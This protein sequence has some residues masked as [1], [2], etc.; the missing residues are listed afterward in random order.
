LGGESPI[1]WEEGKFMIF[2]R[3]LILF[4]LFAGARPLL[5]QDF[6][7]TTNGNA[8]EEEGGF[9]KEEFEVMRKS[10][11]PQIR[12]LYDK[13]TSGR[14]SS[15]KKGD[16]RFS[17][18]LE[19]H[20]FDLDGISDHDN[21]GNSLEGGVEKAILGKDRTGGEGRQK[22][23]S[24]AR[25][26]CLS[27]VMGGKPKPCNISA[28]VFDVGAAHDGEDHKVYDLNPAVKDALK[29][30]GEA[31]FE[32]FKED[33]LKQG[34]T[35]DQRDYGNDAIR[36]EAA[37]LYKQWQFK[38]E[39]SWKTLRAARLA[40]FR[41]DRPDS[42]DFAEG[43]AFMKRIG[44]GLSKNGSDQSLAEQV[45]IQGSVMDK[46]FCEVAPANS[47]KWQLCPPPGRTPATTVGPELRRS[48][49]GQLLSKNWAPPIPAGLQRTY[50]QQA[51]ARAREEASKDPQIQK[52]IA[53]IRECMSPSKWCSNE[54]LPGA[55]PPVKKWEEFKGDPGV[56]FKDTREPL[57]MKMSL[58]SKL[59][60]AQQRKFVSDADFTD[61]MAGGKKNP[62]YAQWIEYIDD[63]ENTVNDIQAMAK[64]QREQTVAAGGKA[65]YTLEQ[66]F[67]PNKKTVLEMFG[68]NPV[69]NTFS[70]DASSPLGSSSA[71]K[72]STPPRPRNPIDVGPLS[73]Q[74]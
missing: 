20:D 5:A 23:L 42:I 33:V 45:A 24:K 17:G 8:E 52:N 32:Q 41:T 43:Q 3:F 74:R 2:I 65:D 34:R 58:A 1:K 35:D 9:S 61:R 19:M 50:Y 6:A 10:N 37:W 21:S 67:D 66:T 73:P 51:L 40:G 29:K 56:V 39:T 25:G 63:L 22:G 28:V 53:K 30:A 60:L 62:I 4:F 72:S 59:P 14:L 12:A 46:L 48:A 36:S 16:S 13:L 44:E 11:D 26:D 49:L 71:S 70:T 68:S 7:D 47:N 54:D 55:Q 38:V 15:A 27:G 57:Y 31:Y 18:H 64:K 69:N